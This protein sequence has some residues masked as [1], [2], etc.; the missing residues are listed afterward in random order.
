MRAYRIVKRSRAAEAFSGEGARLFGGR[1]NHPGEPMVY[2]AQTRALAA[3][4]TLAHY[5]GA[6]R[7]IE[8]VAF[9]I[10][11]PDECV[12]ALDRAALPPDWRNA[13]PPSATQDL[14]SDWQRNLASVC[15]AVP[16]AIIP[17]EYC[18]LLNPQHPD[19]RKVMIHFPSEF[20]LD[21]RL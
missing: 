16:S 14:G 3:L 18:V 21:R 15:L 2:A 9:E 6:E 20:R 4:E 8:F 5:A 7:R 19:A 17:E 1:W 13:I 12:I 10:E 11:V